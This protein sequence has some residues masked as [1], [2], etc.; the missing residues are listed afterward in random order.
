MRNFY[1]LIILIIMFFPV[2]SAMGAEDNKI[3]FKM[4]TTASIQ[5]PT[6]KTLKAFKEYVE[7]K[8][9]GALEVSLHGAGK[10]GG[11][12]EMAE[13]IQLGIIEMG[14]ITSA[15]LGNFVPELNVLEI[16]FLFPSRQVMYEVIDGPAGKKV[17]E[18]LKD[19]G[20]VGTGFYGEVG[21]RDF[22]NSQKAIRT[23]DDFKGLKFRVHESRISIEM[24]RMLG[25]NPIPLPFPELFTALQRG[26]VDGHDLPLTVTFVTKFYEVTEHITD[27]EFIVTTMPYI[28]NK[29][30]FEGLPQEYQQVIIEGA[31]HAQKT[32][33]E[34]NL[35]FREKV[36][37]DLQEQGCTITSITPEERGRFFEALK[38]MR[39]KVVAIYARDDN[40]RKRMKEILQDFD[41]EI[42][43]IQS[44]NPA[45]SGTFG[46]VQPTPGP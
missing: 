37:K 20:F 18:C 12:R 36:K 1:I 2:K 29:D 42:V 15:V 9:N 16:P 45:K 10:L 39:E 30:W 23:P 17:W 8:S 11:E 28:A 7:T 38:P 19:Y 32:N 4:V 41:R 46:A 26:V 31:E 5:H 13:G 25:T 40:T 43:K 21:G 44:A 27:I 34:M 22:T 24:Y 14:C 3:K 6:F 33:R 35:Q